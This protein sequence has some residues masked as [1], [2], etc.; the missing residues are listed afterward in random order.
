M[1][2]NVVVL[3]PQH[4]DPMGSSMCSCKS[5]DPV[6]TIYS[7]IKTKKGAVSRTLTR[8]CFKGFNTCMRKF[9]LICLTVVFCVSCSKVPPPKVFNPKADFERANEKL[10]DEFLV[11]IKLVSKDNKNFSITC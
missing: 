2:P 9:I 10:E 7:G 11:K 3:S 6:T 8:T 1:R 4:G 5:G